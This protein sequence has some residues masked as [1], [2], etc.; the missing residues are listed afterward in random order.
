MPTRH[1]IL[2]EAKAEYL[3]FAV[4]LILGPNLY[5]ARKIAHHEEWLNRSELV[6]EGSRYAFYR[7]CA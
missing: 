1:P 2:K 3:K 4:K 6:F 5:R 7:V